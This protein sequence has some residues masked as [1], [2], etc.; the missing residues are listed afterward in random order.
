MIHWHTGG[1]TC[2]VDGIRAARSRSSLH[3]SLSLCATVATLALLAPP[4]PPEEPISVMAYNVLYD[5]PDIEKSLDAIDRAKPDILCLREL[6]TP[7]ARAFERR[8]GSSFPNRALFPK[9]VGTWGLGLA[10]R[11]PLSSAVVFEERPH[12][13]PA[14]QAQVSTPSGRVL[15]ACL[16]LFPPVGKHRKS[17]GF[18]ETMNKN[19]ELRHKQAQFIVTRY[20]H[21]Q[22]PLL[23]VGDMNEGP[24]GAAVRTFE[25]AGLARSCDSGSSRC[26]PTFPGATSMFPAIFEIDHIL[27][28]DV[29]F[30]T[31]RVIRE[32][33]SDH[34]P[35]FAAFTLKKVRAGDPAK[36]A[37]ITAPAKTTP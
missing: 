20:S 13:L 22:G 2:L 28:R 8:L 17:D 10:S 21:T 6:S 11:F 31:A 36:R 34:F 5:A 1:S 35:V 9:S 25:K 15:V 30:A 26:G 29:E 23:V 24:D 37:R 14:I 19:A 16:H 7:F 12:K 4:T 33:G 3:M 27:G 18:L 32:G